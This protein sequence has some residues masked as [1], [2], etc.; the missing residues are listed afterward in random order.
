MTPSLP[1]T[2]SAIRELERTIAE[3]EAHLAKKNVAEGITRLMAMREALKLV[4]ICEQI[5]YF[6]TN[7][8]PASPGFKAE[9]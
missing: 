2:S 4:R 1:P 9:N 6:E 5:T 3:R 7:G 8:S